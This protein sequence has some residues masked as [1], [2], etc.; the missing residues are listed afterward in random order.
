M[1]SHLRQLIISTAVVCTGSLL[2]AG[3]RSVCVKHPGTLA[4]KIGEDNKY[5]V[6]ALKIKGSLNADDVR[7][8]REMAGGDSL[9]Q[10]TP[11]KLVDI[12]LSEVSFTPGPESIL[13]SNSNYRIT[14]KHSIPPTFLYNCP[15]EKVVLP[16]QLDSIGNWAFAGT[17]LKELLIPDGVNVAQRVIASDSLA[18]RVGYPDIQGQAPS[19]SYLELPGIRKIS[20]GDV[21]YVASGS[22]VNL[23]DLEEI[24]FE[25]L[26]GHIDGYTV[27]NCPKLKRIIFKGPVA[28]TGGAQFVKDCPE[29]EEVSFNGLVFATGFGSPV[30]CP[31]MKGYN[32]NG[33]VLY[34]DSSLFRIGTPADVAADSDM[35]RQAMKLMDYKTRSLKNPSLKFL[36]MIEIGNFKET[37]S[38]AD[39]LG[40]SA[41]FEGLE[42]EILPIKADMEKSKL[43]LLRESPAYRADEVNLEWSYASPSDSILRFDREFFNLDSI[44]GNGDDVS[45]IKNLM[46]W[47]HDAVRHD[48]RS[49]N[50]T[51]I[52]LKDIIDLCIKENRGVNCRMM[53]IMLTEALLAEGIP[54]R[55]LTCQPKLWAFDSDCHVICMAWSESLGKWVWVDPTF[56]AYVTDEN[57]QMLHPGEVRERLIEDKPLILNPDANWNHQSEQTKEDY[58][59]RYMAKNLYYITAK[60]HNCPRPEGVNAVKSSY[61]LLSPVDSKTA[62]EFNIK[63][64]D[65][66]RFWAAPVKQ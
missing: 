51:S 33:I 61:V 52:S 53:A 55:Y 12:D 27:T 23:P 7:F 2:L 6:R 57:G 21:D 3:V 30:N 54:A 26:V 11:G 18:E 8:L 14:G 29:L 20:Y 46:Y 13:G 22:F 59:D 60:E 41:V 56:A 16:K 36:E 5:E 65:Y 4:D 10:K 9:F 62:P 42:A 35:R 34:G 44:A 24:V 28:S 1:K 45:R 38:L 40:E 32:Q 15:V 47:V 50:P 25:G 64:T 48:G 49:Y 63:T 19:P 43:E 37:E 17:K 58:L 66:N 31:K 39:A